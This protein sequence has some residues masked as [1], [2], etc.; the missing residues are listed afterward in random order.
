MVFLIE[1]CLKQ[2]SGELLQVVHGSEY[3][4]KE[5]CE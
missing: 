4:W 3:F 1:D 2:F 5:K